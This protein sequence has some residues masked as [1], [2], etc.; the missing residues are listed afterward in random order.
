MS[1]SVAESQKLLDGGVLPLVSQAL[2]LVAPI[3]PG[4]PLELPLPV[5]RVYREALLLAA[6]VAAGPARHK[7]ALL[8]TRILYHA[9]R[10]TLVRCNK[11]MLDSFRLVTNTASVAVA[12]AADAGDAA[13]DNRAVARKLLTVATTYVSPLP[14]PPPSANVPPHA[15][16]K[17][18]RTSAAVPAA[19]KTGDAPALKLLVL[20]GRQAL[21]APPAATNSDVLCARVEALGAMLQLGAVA[22]SNVDG[23]PAT[24][25]RECRESY[26]EAYAAL[27]RDMCSFGHRDVAA[28]ATA[29]CDASGQ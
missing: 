16:A 9:F 11:V 18:A 12:D 1:D 27:A 13:A 8:E 3:Y 5:L 29:V 17:T 25:A 19:V 7:L 2:D 15:G 21:A 24:T 6:N 4:C 28:A 20:R 22:G 14:T 23:G 10:G 26:W